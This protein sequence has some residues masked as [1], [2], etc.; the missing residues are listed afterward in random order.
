MFVDVSKGGEETFE[1]HAH[2]A[3]FHIAEVLSEV[4]VLE[5]WEH[6]NNLVLVSEG[7]NEWAY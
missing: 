4:S 7:S 6:S 1:V 3:D 2:I 5:V